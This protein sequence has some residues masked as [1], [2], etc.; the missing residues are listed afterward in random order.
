MTTYDVVLV[1]ALGRMHNHYL[2][3]VK[4][5][6]RRLRIGICRAELK[7]PVKTSATETLFLELCASFGA[8]PLPPGRHRT[9]LLVLPQFPYADEFLPALAA[10]IE[11][12]RKVVLQTFGYGNI[13][14]EPIARAGFSRLWVYDRAILDGKLKTEADRR[15]VEDTF[16]I[17]EMGSPFARY[18]VFDD[19]SADYMI[20]FPTE[21]SFPTPT[22]K[23]RFLHN[24]RRLLERL[25]VS[26]RVVVKP[27]NVLDGGREVLESGSRMFAA[28]RALRRLPLGAVAA[29]LGRGVLSAGMGSARLTGPLAR[30]AGGFD[31]AAVMDRAE[32]L[33][34]FTP[35]FN[36]GLEL[37]LPGVRLGLIT[38]RSSSVW[39]ALV[40][41]VP[42]FNCD[43][44]TVAAKSVGVLDAYASY[45]VPPCHGRLVFDERAFGRIADSVRQADLLELLQKEM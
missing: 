27:H 35:C 19:F 10:R 40:N 21:L 3:I 7:K 36:F 18:P 25:P 41:N 29:A 28:G 24:V 4:H 12:D 26:A 30:F 20:A 16:D 6:G 8:E 17:V 43:D 23:A 33:S 37:F 14:L 13:C 9:R 38:G 42:V 11:T 1:H 31:Y 2:N 44:E 15:F 32:P 45:G 22:G 34:R 39:H 5:L